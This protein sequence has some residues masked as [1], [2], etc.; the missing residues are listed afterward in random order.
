MRNF[1]NGLLAASFFCCSTSFA[2]PTVNLNVVH[3][4]GA[5]ASIPYEIDYCSTFRCPSATFFSAAV[6][7]NSAD[8]IN[9]TPYYENFYNK[10]IILMTFWGRTTLPN[11]DSNE[12][13]SNA[14]IDFT[15]TISGA[16]AFDC[17]PESFVKKVV[18][19]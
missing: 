13:N 14:H 2:L 17:T 8:H 10:H 9:L 1:K 3:N 18:R 7:P 11:I 19:N 6:A 15:V 12:I 4:C 16:T 5:T